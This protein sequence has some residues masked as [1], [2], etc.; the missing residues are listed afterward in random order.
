MHSLALLSLPHHL[1][2]LPCW[3]SE[4]S[5]FPHHLPFLYSRAHHITSDLRMASLTSYHSYPVWYESCLT[6]D[7][8]FARRMRPDESQR[9]TRHSI[10][11]FW[12]SRERRAV[13]FFRTIYVSSTSQKPD[14]KETSARRFVHQ[15]G[16][17]WKTLKSDYSAMGH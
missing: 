11:F 5:E 2:S 8:F 4:T 10:P 3:R 13:H 6:L 17:C 9:L 1:P 15:E 7:T 14:S 16:D 12:N